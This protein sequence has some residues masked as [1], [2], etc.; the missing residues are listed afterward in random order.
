MVSSP[1]SDSVN[2]T[3]ASDFRRRIAAVAPPCFSSTCPQV[4]SALASIESFLLNAFELCHATS[5]SQV[6]RTLAPVAAR[7]RQGKVVLAIRA[8]LGQR[9]DMVNFD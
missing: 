6:G 5:H 1:T 7:V 9:D 8:L 3:R 2:S 4:C